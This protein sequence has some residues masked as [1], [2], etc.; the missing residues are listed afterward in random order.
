MINRRSSRRGDVMWLV[1][2]EFNVADG[3]GYL[4]FLELCIFPELFLT[5]LFFFTNP[6]VVM[7]YLGFVCGGKHW[8]IYFLVTETIKT[9]DT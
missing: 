6:F 3:Y 2:F 7:S 4:H 5:V 9:L 1:Q 8:I